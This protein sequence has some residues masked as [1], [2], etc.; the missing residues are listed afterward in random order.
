MNNKT[1]LV[2]GTYPI[3]V[4]Q[5]GGQ[6]RLAA[7]VDEYRGMFER[8]QYT[9]VYCADF[10]AQAGPGDIPISGDSLQRV[11]ESPFTGDVV[12]G[13]AIYD[14]PAVRERMVNVITNLQPAVIHIEQPFP[15]IGLKKLLAELEIKPKIIFGSQNIEAPMKRDIL[16]NANAPQAFTDEIVERIDALERELSKDADLVMACTE[17]DIAAHKKMGAKKVVL[18]QNGIAPFE[19]TPEATEYWKRKFAKKNITKTALFVASAHPP[20]W[21]G[22]E[23]MI[24][25][26]V[27]FMPLGSQL[28]LAGSVSDYFESRVTDTTDIKQVTF[29]Q[30][31]TACGRL[32]EERLVALLQLADVIVLPITEGGGSNLKTAEALI[33]DKPVVATSH[34]FRSYENFMGFPNIYIA[35]KPGDFRAAIANALTATPQPRTAAQAQLVQEVL[36]ENR[37]SDAMK[38]VTKL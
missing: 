6:K 29:W 31:V 19:T 36:W 13:E 1:I 37:L 16:Q 32:P 26:G 11:R 2:I 38:E 25:Y 12:C 10:Y 7:I 14:D 3:A 23:E 24:G 8:V 22:F 21:T 18:A 28:L 34:A 30:R 27:G 15:Y 4:P 5:H 9:A 17:A 33:A 20:S 35:D